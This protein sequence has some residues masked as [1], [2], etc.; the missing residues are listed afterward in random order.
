MNQTMTIEEHREYECVEC[1]TTLC[2]CVLCKPTETRQFMFKDDPNRTI[3]RVCYYRI[4]GIQKRPR[5]YE[6]RKLT[7][8]KTR[9]VMK[10]Y[11]ATP[12]YAEICRELREL[13]RTYK[14]E[15]SLREH[16][17]MRALTSQTI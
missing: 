8:A 5:I 1:K 14:K 2:L 16:V 12:K 4:Y 17:L 10:A 13:R 11:R 15:V 6:N 7:L 3:C 9:A